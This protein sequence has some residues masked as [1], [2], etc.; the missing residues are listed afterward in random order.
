MAE[1]CPCNGCVPPRRNADCH[2]YCPDYKKWNDKHL[3]ELAMI[4]EMRR[5]YSD[6]FPGSLYKGRNKKGKMR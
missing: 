2:T 5:E 1:P 4:R 3:Q 6:C